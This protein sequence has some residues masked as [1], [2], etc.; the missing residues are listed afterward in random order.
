ME[1]FNLLDAAGSLALTLGL[2]CLY[3]GTIMEWSEGTPGYI[4][5]GLT[6]VGL[7]IVGHPLYRFF[8]NVSTIASR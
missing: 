5:T 6:G 8:D 3:A 2:Y 4:R 7:G 1:K